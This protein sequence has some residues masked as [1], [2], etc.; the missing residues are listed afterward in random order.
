MDSTKSK[1]KKAFVLKRNNPAQHWN[2]SSKQSVIRSAELLV[3]RE[4]RLKLLNER[5]VTTFYTQISVATI[6]ILTSVALQATIPLRVSSD[7]VIDAEVRTLHGAG[8]AHKHMVTT[9]GRWPIASHTK[10]RFCATTLPNRTGLSVTDRVCRD[11]SAKGIEAKKNCWRF[12][13]EEQDSKSYR[14]GGRLECAVRGHNDIHA[15]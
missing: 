10:R 13:F 2:E 15:T 11:T 8:D 12:V 3:P 14:P 9:A 6:P 4:R 1:K 7:L 5:A